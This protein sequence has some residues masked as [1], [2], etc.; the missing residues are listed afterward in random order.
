VHGFLAH[1]SLFKILPAKE[2]S[3]IVGDC[4]LCRF[5]SGDKVFEEG[6][7]AGSV[8]IIKR[9]WVF[10]TKQNPRGGTITIFTMT[11]D[12]A[13][14]GISAFDHGT[15]STGAVAATDSQLI[16]IPSRVFSRLMERYPKFAGR[17][18]LICCE[19]MRHMAESISLAHAP[20]EQRLVHVL[21]RLRKSFGRKIP[22]TH[23]ELARM[24]GTHW[25]TSIR[26]FSSLKRRGLISSTRG[27]ATILAPQKLR[28]LL[29]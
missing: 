18:L 15:Y 14:C 9:G 19:R 28:K 22:V 13:I 10:L 3:N 20:V 7:P 21:L 1:N 2:L 6:Q 11:P 27:E 16:M 26:T 29:A 5:H 8:W 25:E 24:A 4:K 12:E 17:V 23:H